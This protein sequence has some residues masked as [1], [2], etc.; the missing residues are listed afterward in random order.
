MPNRRGC[1]CYR[2]QSLLR[3]LLSGGSCALPASCVLSAC[4]LGVPPLSA[5]KALLHFHSVIKKPGL[6]EISLY[7]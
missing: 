5:L 7:C 4:G 3:S 6:I 2:R 1:S